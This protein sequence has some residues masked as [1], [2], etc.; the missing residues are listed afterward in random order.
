MAELTV[1][2]LI[3]R[4]GKIEPFNGYTTDERERV[5]KTLSENMSDFYTQHLDELMELKKEGKI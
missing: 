4:N 1:N 5:R 2:L 3:E